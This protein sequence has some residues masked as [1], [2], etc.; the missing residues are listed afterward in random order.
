MPSEH[1]GYDVPHDYAGIASM[2]LI[3]NTTR[4]QSQMVH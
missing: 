4:G 1:L 2:P 3:S